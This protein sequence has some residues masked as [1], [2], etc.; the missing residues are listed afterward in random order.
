MKRKVHEKD[1]R[2]QARQ[3]VSDCIEEATVVFEKQLDAY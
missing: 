1:T 3:S 2:F